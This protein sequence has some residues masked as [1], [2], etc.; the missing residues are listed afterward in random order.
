MDPLNLRPFVTDAG[1]EAAHRDEPI[2]EHPRASV[3]EPRRMV[4][5]NTQRTGT[6]KRGLYQA[7]FLI[8]VIEESHGDPA[9]KS[10][11]M[12]HT[13]VERRIKVIE[14]RRRENTFTIVVTVS[15]G[16]PPFFISDLKHP[17]KGYLYSVTVAAFVIESYNTFSL[18]FC[19]EFMLLS[20]H[21]LSLS[22]GPVNASNVTLRQWHNVTVAFQGN[23]PFKPLASATRIDVLWIFSLVL[24]L[25]TVLSA[26][27]APQLQRPFSEIAKQHEAPH[28]YAPISESGSGL[29]PARAV[30]TALQIPMFLSA[31]LFIAGLIDF[32][33]SI[34]K[35]VAFCV[36]GSVPALPFICLA[37][38]ALPSICPYET[39]PDTLRRFRVVG[40]VSQI[41]GLIVLIVVRQIGDTFMMLCRR[42]GVK[43]F[44]A[45]QSVLVL[46]PR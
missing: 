24:V 36:L 43:P 37:C 27:L 35:A 42:F 3:P 2:R 34:N 14:E 22:Q 15:S 9:V 28:K 39:Y 4:L 20:T 1:I 19:D 13:E 21:I 6:S 5:M 44:C 46:L 17:V 31:F 16:I 38:T 45:Q 41:F 29:P 12:D 18:D 7:P 10:W 23:A 8:H 30:E 11:S 33:L 25:V 26:A 40:R 32:L